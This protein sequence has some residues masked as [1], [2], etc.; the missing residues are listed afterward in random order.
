MTLIIRTLVAA[1]TVASTFSASTL[2]AESDVPSPPAAASCATAQHRQF[3]FWLGQWDVTNPAGQLAGHS[4]IESILGG[5]VLLENWDSP[6]G[7]SGKSFNIFNAA[8]GQWEQFWVD[9][10]GS[11]LHLSGGLAAGNMVLQGVQDKPNAQ[12]GLKQHERI[13]WTP[14]ADG[15]VRQ[16]WE[17][18]TD[19]GKSWKTS[20]DGLYR[21]PP[22]GPNG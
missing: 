2:A 21:H 18:S 6:S 17:T 9:N 13:T 5:C 20:F 1:M 8:T 12:S 3:D 11:R 7:V 16:H 10:S 22:G 15:S 19:D 4:R 14:N